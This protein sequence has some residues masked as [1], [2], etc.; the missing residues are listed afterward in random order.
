MSGYYERLASNLEAAVPQRTALARRSALRRR[1]GLAAAGVA[2]LAT[3]C[4]ALAVGGSG[5]GVE[6]AY[7]VTVNPD[8]SVVL[9][10]R[11]LLGVGPANARLARLGIRAR[12][13]RRE[14]GCT[15]RTS[16]TLLP[17]GE[18]GRQMHSEPLPRG[19]RRVSRNRT[20]ELQAERVAAELRF[21]QSM[22]R[23][24]KAKGQFEVVINPAA[25]PR[26]ETLLLAFR[27]VRSRV[28]ADGQRRAS[29]AIGGTIELVK[30]E[31]P[32]CLPSA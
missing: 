15:V 10:V 28:A 30:G 11:E 3:V 5:G 22:L 18:L 13:V 1:R 4:V 25:I 27:T 8:G 6:P 17:P 12:L 9:S 21:L 29:H 20:L 7:A 26:G 24:S 16:A 2:A 14:A 23:P 19:L 31:A 32:R